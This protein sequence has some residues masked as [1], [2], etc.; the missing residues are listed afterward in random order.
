MHK[1][2]AKKLQFSPPTP[3]PPTTPR[4]IY[5]SPSMN[6]TKYYNFLSAP[7]P[8]LPS[9]YLLRPF[10]IYLYSWFFKDQPGPLLGEFLCAPLV[11]EIFWIS[12]SASMSFLMYVYCIC[13]YIKE[14]CIRF[15]FI[16]ENFHISIYIFISYLSLSLYIAL[17]NYYVTYFPHIDFCF[18]LRQ[19]FAFKNRFI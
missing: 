7:P 4:G 1:S 12:K 18:S 14:S 17:I 2:E 9:P 5:V 6:L 10:Y 11:L 19:Q 15:Y 16:H 3:F 13:L 8:P